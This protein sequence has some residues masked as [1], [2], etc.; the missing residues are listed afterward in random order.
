MVISK[1]IFKNFV[2]NHPFRTCIYNVY[3]QTLGLKNELAHGPSLRVG[4]TPYLLLMNDGS[5]DS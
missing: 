1:T 3:Q 4:G 5:P 2:F